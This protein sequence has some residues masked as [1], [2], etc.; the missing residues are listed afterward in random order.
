MDVLEID[1]NN[2]S[3]NITNKINKFNHGEVK[4]DLYIIDQYFL[5]TFPKEIFKNKNYRWLDPGAGTGNFS[6]SIFNRLMVYLQEEIPNSQKR[7]DHII[8]NMLFMVEIN[9]ENIEILKNIFGEKAN[10]YH[11]D[12]LSFESPY[13]FDIIFG[14]PPFNSNGL[15]KVPTNNSLQK[16]NDGNN[17]IKA[18]RYEI[19]LL[20]VKL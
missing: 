10:I 2:H 6:L 18:L 20:A 19:Q 3:G 1:S 11:Q 12:F 8:Q 16:A 7:K 9:S 4:T 13:K 15:K 17:K 5:N 14:N